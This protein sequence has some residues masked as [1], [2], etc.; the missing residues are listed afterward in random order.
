MLVGL[1]PYLDCTAV[2]LP[3]N[4]PDRVGR[5]IRPGAFTSRDDTVLCKALLLPLLPALPLL[6]CPVVL[7]VLSVLLRA[8]AAC[9]VSFAVVNNI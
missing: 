8:A 3:L 9:K 6:A 7:R 5:A 2:V 4:V 1:T